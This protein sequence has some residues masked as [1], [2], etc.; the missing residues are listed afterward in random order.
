MILALILGFPAPAANYPSSAL[1]LL[2]SADGKTVA[3]FD[4][5]CTVSWDAST[6][7]ELHDQPVARPRKLRRSGGELAVLVGALGTPDGRLTNVATGD[8]QSA[9]VFPASVLP[10]MRGASAQAPSSACGAWVGEC[11][12]WEGTQGSVAETVRRASRLE[13]NPPSSASAAR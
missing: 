12:P 9:L 10:R 11:W 13:F 5:V 4:N 3:A 1:G 6:G 2:F 8:T 7:A